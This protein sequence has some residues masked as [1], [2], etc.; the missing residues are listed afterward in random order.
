MI[1]DLANGTRRTASV[2]ILG[3]DRDAI[4]GSDMPERRCDGVR[5]WRFAP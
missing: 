2:R 5:D 4:R 3:Q 1:G